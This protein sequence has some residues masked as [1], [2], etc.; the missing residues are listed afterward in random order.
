MSLQRHQRRQFLQQLVNH[1]GQVP[2][3]LAGGVV[4]GVAHGAGVLLWYGLTL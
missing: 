3:A 1:H 2:D 4:D